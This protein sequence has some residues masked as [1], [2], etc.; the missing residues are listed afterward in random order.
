MKHHNQSKTQRAKWLL[1]IALATGTA[2]ALW[3]QNDSEEIFE[4]SPFEVSA[5]K[6][7]IG[8]RQQNTL[9]GSR[10]STNV[11]DLGASISVI[12]K[13]QMEDT[14]SLDV[15]DLFRYEANTEGS[16]T[17][18]PSVQS[19]R[20]DGVVDV[21]AG[22]TH[23]GDG[24]PQTNAGANRVRGI[25]TPDASINFY[26]AIRNVPLDTYNVQ[27]VEISRGPS[28]MLFGIG[29][30]AGFVNQSRS[31]AVLDTK[32]TSLKFR[33]D[34]NGSKRFSVSTNQPLI[35][36][37]LAI[38]FAALHD[39]KEFERQPS[40]D[41][42]RREYVALTYKPFENTRFKGSF[43]NYRNK[44][45][46][47]NTLT[48]RDYVSEWVD[49]G[50]PAYDPSS[51]TVT[52]LDSGK[53]VGPFVGRTDSPYIDEVRAYIM[54]LP[55][56]DATKWNTPNSTGTN[57]MT[58]Y[59]GV[60]I[61]G[62]QAMTNVDSALYVPGLGVANSRPTM[63]VANS[64]VVNWF[65]AAP[66][67]YRAGWGT[68][69][70]PAA[71]QSLIPSVASI[72]ADLDTAAA[73]NQF[74]TNSANYS[75]N[76]GSIGS[77]RYP[78]VTDTSIYDYTSVNILSM[79]FGEDENQT[80]NLEFE[81]KIT[82]DLFL[83]AG[84]FRQD[85]DSN[86][87]YTVSQLNV[88]T[89]FVDTN[90]TLP[91]GQANPYFG[92][93]YVED[94]D[95]DRFVNR[96]TSDQY[97]A[98]LAYTPDF[99]ERDGWTKW[100]GK[101]QLLA[102]ASKE[103]VSRD[104]IRQR[105]NFTGGDE[106]ANGTIRYLA[107]ENNNADGTPTGWRNEGAS[108][109]RTYYLAQPG[110]P[111]GTV[112]STA[113]AIDYTS[114]TGPL[115]AY[116]LGNETWENISMTHAFKD[117]SAST[118]RSQTEIKSYNLGGTSYFWNDRIIAT[119]GFRNDV[120]K[121]RFSSPNEIRDLD[122]NLI[123]ESMTNPARWINGI[124]Q[125]DTV[126]KR[127]SA[128]SEEEA[129]TATTGVVVKPLSNFDKIKDKAQSGSLFHQ[130]INS[131]GFSYN[132]SD[133]FNP[134]TTTNID[135][136][137]TILPL[138]EGEGKDYGIQFSL[139]ENKL[140]ARISKYESTNDNERTNGG[141]PISRL[142]GNVDT[143]TFRAWGRT[144]AL[145]NAGHD[146]RLEGFG[147]GLTPA[148]EESIRAATTPI[149]GQDY[150]Y[151]DTLP[152]SIAAT[153]SAKA[154]G[155]ELQLTYNPTQNWNIKLT[156]AKS[157]TRYYNVLKE[158]DAWL[159]HRLPVWQ[160]ARAADYLLPQY[161]DL[162]T[163]TTPGGAQVNLTNFLSSYGY[164]THIRLQDADPVDSAQQY[165]DSVVTPQASLAKDL[166]G[167]VSP[168]QSK[169]TASL[170]TNYKFL[171]DKLRGVAIGGSLR[172]KDEAVIGYYGKSS[173]ANP[174][175]NYIDIANTLRPIYTPAESYYDLWA[176]YTRK[177]MKDEVNMKVQLNI[178]NAFENGGLQTVGVNYDGSPNAYRIVDPRQFI[179]NVSFDM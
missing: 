87:S 155:T 30:P 95:P 11:A 161:Q 92:L 34:Y 33:V 26:R 115:T 100:F 81:Q 131:L 158:Y 75:Q 10:L 179:L 116:N 54:A 122:G 94:F 110:D 118:N 63:Q 71:N 97:R 123:H 86:S 22:Y 120:A 36:D 154:E 6:D 150:L 160:A 144:I 80:Y 13:Q 67:Q 29:S 137:G 59:N 173:G 130:F 39:D 98:A 62:S 5:S 32:S 50:R 178:V 77:Y 102:Y 170:I 147:E 139:F 78:G 2:P 25:G 52:F 125:T 72:Q 134:P 176:S 168:G 79:N 56:Y 148:E 145:I 60:S 151:Y 109:R 17:Y 167:Q 135:V 49:A 89:L 21:N 141:T 108:T 162:A 8:Y 14:A 132:K 111:Y 174:D 128:W 16:S 76:G 114:Y 12:T 133:T 117:H 105:L 43:E 175:P 107:N 61:V 68:A 38:Y 15:N 93:P 106:V 159:A 74:W 42:T 46:R 88:A 138:P 119:Y 153:R 103:D 156:G 171:G 83:T 20:N 58:S 165:F 55:N 143:N 127:L 44:N 66:G 45:N 3:A 35:E 164:V 23:G 73:Y 28:S 82:D 91:N 70:N 152:G 163:Y 69:S 31:T 96:I 4:L 177:I 166:E 124:Y 7:D 41:D 37:K 113:G 18:T 142:T 126:F 47:P 84:W 40:Y 27:S 112:T 19:L 129:D 85:F 157:E 24:Q 90:L 99:T 65:Q 169:Y 101:H 57:A 1:A 149:W 140:F 64:Q 172:W 121:N 9:A 51:Q 48:P 53:V 104:F 146:P 136:F